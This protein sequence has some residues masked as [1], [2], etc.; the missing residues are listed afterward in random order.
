MS[1]K[2]FVDSNLWL[3]AF[4]LRPGEEVRHE[5]AKALIKAPVL[6]TIS[7]QVI[8]EV[9]NNLLKKAQMREDRLLAIIE[10]FYVRCQVVAP[11]IATHR[12]AGRLRQAYRFSYWDSLIVAV[13][14]EAGCS[15]LYSE[16]MQHSLEIDSRLTILNPLIA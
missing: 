7:E 9:S 2:A 10:S 4:A 15:I 13:A 5:R 12:A 14:L 3:Y 16:D 6:Y 1:D 11:D 8:A